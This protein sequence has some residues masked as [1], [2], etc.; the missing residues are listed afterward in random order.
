MKEKCLE[1]LFIYLFIYQLNSSHTLQPSKFKIVDLIALFVLVT[2]TFLD[3]L[4]CFFV[5]LIEDTT[6]MFYKHIQIM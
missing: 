4:V 1:C 6:V 2:S 5:W 3:F